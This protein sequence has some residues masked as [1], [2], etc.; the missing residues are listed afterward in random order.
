MKVALDKLFMLKINGPSRWSD[1]RSTN[2]G[3]GTKRQGFLVAQLAH[4]E[5][6]FFRGP[7]Q[8]EWFVTLREAKMRP[9]HPAWRQDLQPVIPVVLGQTHDLTGD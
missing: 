2:A 1:G 7:E 3:K 6:P 4:E 9:A 5:P 8:A